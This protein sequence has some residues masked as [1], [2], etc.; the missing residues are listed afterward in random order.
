MHTFLYV[1]VCICYGL[2]VLTP[3]IHFEALT[4]TPNI[5]M[6]FRDKLWEVIRVK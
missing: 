3:K 5:V 4:T 2:N 1:Y 6:V